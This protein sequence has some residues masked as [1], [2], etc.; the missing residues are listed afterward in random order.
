MICEGCNNEMGEK[1]YQAKEIYDKSEF[2]KI[3]RMNI[4]S[5]IQKMRYESAYC[6]GCY[7]HHRR[8]IKMGLF[9]NAGKK[10]RYELIKNGK[11]IRTWK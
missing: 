11:I 1:E 2:E 3:K 6:R 7:L 8:R 5:I 4:Q 10:D 9:T